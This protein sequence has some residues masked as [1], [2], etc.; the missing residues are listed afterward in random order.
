MKKNMTIFSFLIFL[1]F[2]IY[3]HATNARDYIPLPDGTTLLATYYKHI[4]ANSLYERGNKVSDD[5]NLNAHVGILR[6]VFY[7]KIG[8]AWYGDGGLIVDP[9]A[10]IIFGSQSVDGAAVG[11]QNLSDSGLFDSTVLATFW[12]VNAPEEKFWIGFSPYITMP[13]GSYSKNRA[14]NLGENRWAFKPEIGIVKGFGE[15]TYVDL[16]LNTEFYTDNRDYFLAPGVRGK[17]SQDPMFGATVHVSHDITDKLY[18][19]LDYFYSYG[20]ENKID[21]VKEDDKA[22]NHGIGLSMFYMVGD[23]N[24]LMFEYRNDFSVRN[25]PQTQTIGARWAYFF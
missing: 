2:P 24:Q 22:N 5:F 25:G 15:K 16:V 21:G 20:G 11:N 4:T 1:F 18:L 23:S 14:F 13:I 12:F 10:L 7:K 8:E 9:Q 19:S 3:S 17:R 6:P